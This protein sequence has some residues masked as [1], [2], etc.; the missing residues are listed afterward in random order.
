[1]KKSFLFTFGSVA[2]ALSQAAFAV[3]SRLPGAAVLPEVNQEAT[4][5]LSF[6]EAS[7]IGSTLLERLA[8]EVFQRELQEREAQ[9]QALPQKKSDALDLSLIHI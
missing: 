4:E 3:E 7:T 2:I 8:G 6:I 5:A 1:M 9:I